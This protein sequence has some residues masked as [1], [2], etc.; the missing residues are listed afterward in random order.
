VADGWSVKALHRRILLS[1]TYTQ[2]SD[3]RPELT[4]ADPENR[5]LGRANR[6][7]L[8]FESLRDGLLAAAGKLDRMVGGRSVDLFAAPFPARRTLYAKID[9]QNL[10]AAFRAFVT[11][12]P[13][14]ALWLM[15]GPFAQQQAKAVAGRGQD[16]AGVYRAVLGRNPTPAEVTQAE[17]FVA[18][19]SGNG[20]ELLA[21]ALLMS[22]EFAF[23]D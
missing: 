20:R 7:R 22:N 3:A 19:V 23:V 10:P 18:G 13:Q 1:D 14:Q 9:R 16:I 8:D 12:V 6:R 21:Q 5:L 17:A 4:A 11:T 2:R 15:N